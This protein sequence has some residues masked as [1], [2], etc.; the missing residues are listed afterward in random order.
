MG[1]ATQSPMAYTP[2]TLV[3][4]LSLITMRLALSSSTPIF[5][6]PRSS[7]LGRR[8]TAT[9]TTS[10]SNFSLAPPAA[11]SSVSDTP[12]GR[13]SAATTLVLSLKSKARVFLSDLWKAS[14]ISLSMVAQ[15]RSRNSITVTLAPRRAHTEP[16]SRPMT[17]PPMTARDLGTLGRTRAPVD[18]TQVLSPASL[19]FMKGSSTGSDP[20]AMMVF[21]VFHVV[22]EPSRPSTSIVFASVK[23]P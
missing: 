18:D 4:K 3:A 21:L 20:V 10:A 16:S 15:M 9:S 12:S 2:L 6:R 13:M 17:P 5:S 22:F 8:P 23:R 11:G 14:V 19:N 7:V 1:P